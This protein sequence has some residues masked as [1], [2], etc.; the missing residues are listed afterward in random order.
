MRLGSKLVSLLLF[1]GTVSRDREQLKKDM[2]G[3]EPKTKKLK[4]CQQLLTKKNGS[5][6][7]HLLFGCLMELGQSMQTHII[8]EHVFPVTRLPLCIGFRHLHDEQ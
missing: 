7:C 4:T 3:A 8:F 2:A 1:L 6:D 5:R